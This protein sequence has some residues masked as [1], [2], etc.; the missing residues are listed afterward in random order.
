MPRRISNNPI[1][2]IS[3]GKE[4]GETLFI[5]GVTGL[6]LNSFKTPNQTKIIPIEIRKSFKAKLD[7]LH[8]MFI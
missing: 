3:I 7:E 6:E 4:K 1:R 5:S 2:G 8:C